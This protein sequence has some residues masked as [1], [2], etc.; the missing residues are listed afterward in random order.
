MLKQSLF[1]QQPNKFYG[2]FGSNSMLM[3]NNLMTDMTS[4]PNL[5]NWK[6]IYNT[7]IN[8]SPKNSEPEKINIIF[9]TTRG[10]K[11]NICIEKNKSLSD[12]ILLYL[13]RMNKPELFCCNNGLL[14]LYDAKKV[15]IYDKTQVGVAF[16]GFSFPTIIVNEF[17]NLI[18]A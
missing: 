15:D 12:A 11:T 4:L 3:H 14:F 16:N 8:F 5:D 2:M 1:H 13:K 7:G 17:K 6:N 10:V 9:N 18:G